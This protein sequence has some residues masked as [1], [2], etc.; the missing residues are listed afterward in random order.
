VSPIRYLLPDEV[1]N[2]VAR[3]SLDFN[4][5]KS[6]NQ[7][8]HILGTCP[9]CKKQ[10]WHNASHI[11]ARKEVYTGYCRDCYEMP[12]GHL[13]KPLLLEEVSSDVYEYLYFD[14]QQSFANKIVIDVKCKRC[15]EI[16]KARVS[17]IRKSYSFT[18]LCKNCRNK[19]EYNPRW[20]GY[21]HIEKDG[22]ARVKISTLDPLYAFLK[23]MLTTTGKLLEHRLVMAIKQNRPLERY[24]HVHH[25]NHIKTD[26]RPENLEIVT[27][28]N[29]AVITDLEREINRL[30]T[31]NE[32]LRKQ[33]NAAEC[34]NRL[35]S[36]IIK[37]WA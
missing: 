13:W 2:I 10:I 29:H 4:S 30:K 1:P 6:I 33:L 34:I 31:E 9:R 3:N 12:K 19:D 24:E 37:D 17:N 18:T 26:N 25:I 20:Q 22:Y 35:F 16:W 28:S 23:P 5:Q 15:G 8:L 36:P 7:R 21:R 14:K 27:P 11:R 32:K